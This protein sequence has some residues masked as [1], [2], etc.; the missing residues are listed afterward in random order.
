MEKLNCGGEKMKILNVFLSLLFIVFISHGETIKDT[1]HGFEVQLPGDY[2]ISA[3]STTGKIII[4]HISSKKG[5]SIFFLKNPPKTKDPM[6]LL[7]VLALPLGGNIYVKKDKEN[8]TGFIRAPYSYFAPYLKYSFVYDMF[9]KGIHNE[10]AN[11][12][13]VLTKGKKF[14]MVTFYLYQTKED[15][16][17]LSDIVSSFRLLK[18][19]VKYSRRYIKS[20]LFGIPAMYVDIPAGFKIEH[21]LTVTQSGE[22]QSVII[23][24]NKAK[25]IY[26]GTFGDTLINNDPFMPFAYS[27]FLDIYTGQLRNIQT[28]FQSDEDFISFV[29]NYLGINSEVEY[30]GDI[31]YPYLPDLG[32]SLYKLS[33]KDAYG[34][35]TTIKKTVQMGTQIYNSYSVF[36]NGVFGKDKNKGVGILISIEEN[37]DWVSKN[38]KFLT[39][40]L[41]K[42]IEHQRW[43]WKEFRKTQ[44]YINKLHRKMISEEQVYQE[45]MARALTNILSDYTY[46]RDPETG[47]IFHLENEYEQYWRDQEGNIMGLSG[48]VDERLL[49]AN[50]FKKLQVRLEGFGQW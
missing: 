49:E 16:K 48:D 24:G 31:Q 43:L 33:S 18:N 20:D 17:E 10:P 45:E 11:G 4:M 9:L 29:F 35:L 23:Q 26:G 50:G 47:E 1:L 42:E 38:M 19:R 6:Y 39:H 30:M 32:F 22:I 2:F 21:G 13:F 46:A 25:V 7:K 14:T 8:V 44:D 15:L 5:V 37:P 3:S 34:F 12:L 36:I 27:R 41:K 40:E 28:L